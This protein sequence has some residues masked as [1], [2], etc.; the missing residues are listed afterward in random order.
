MKRHTEIV[1]HIN[2]KKDAFVHKEKNY[3]HQNIQNMHKALALN[4]CGKLSFWKCENVSS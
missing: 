4:K 2:L 3:Y 1:V